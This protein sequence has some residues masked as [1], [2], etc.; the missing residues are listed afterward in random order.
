MFGTQ[1]IHRHIGIAQM[2]AR[3]RMFRMRRTF[4]VCLLQKS[5]LSCCTVSNHH[6]SGGGK[7]KA[8]SFVGDLKISVWL[9]VAILS[10]FMW[11]VLILQEDR[12]THPSG[13]SWAPSLLGIHKNTHPVHRLFR[14]IFPF[15]VLVSQVAIAC[16]S[17]C[18][19]FWGKVTGKKRS[20]LAIQGVCFGRQRVEPRKVTPKGLDSFL[21]VTTGSEA[22]EAAVKLARRSRIRPRAQRGVRG[23]LASGWYLP[24]PSKG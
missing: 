7:G 10:F 20:P 11:G 15:C 17:H 24:L 8:N 21:F 16:F 14:A 18:C 2:E 4:D 19:W 12:Q 3:I 1:R 13:S 6:G 9:P 5:T 23:S 22:V